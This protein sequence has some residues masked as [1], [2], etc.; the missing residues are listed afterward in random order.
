MAKCGMKTE[1]FSRVCGYHRPIKNWNKG[2]Q[3][4]F[5]DRKVFST[6]TKKKEKVAWFF[7][8]GNF[9][10]TTK[11]QRHKCILMI[12][13]SVPLCLSG[14]LAYRNFKI[15]VMRALVAFGAAIGG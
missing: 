10:L 3:E 4:E 14:W 2:K 7:E 8:K 11:A 5:K 9:I 13:G 1:I 6:E 15:E 12:Y